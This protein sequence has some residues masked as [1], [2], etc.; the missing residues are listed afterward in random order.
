MQQYKIHRFLF[1]LSPVLPPG[2]TNLVRPKPSKASLAA[3]L[4]ALPLPLPPYPGPNDTVKSNSAK[5]KPGHKP[6]P[7]QTRGE[8]AERGKREE[9]TEMSVDKGGEM[10]ALWN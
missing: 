3:S 10:Q 6:P 8:G 4:S 2:L 1:S 5:A 7:Y 9:Q